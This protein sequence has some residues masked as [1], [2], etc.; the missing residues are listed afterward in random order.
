M[1][2]K[3]AKVSVSALVALMFQS[4]Y[5]SPSPFAK[6]FLLAA[7][8]DQK[9]A[10]QTIVDSG[11]GHR[12]RVIDPDKV[13]VDIM[14]AFPFVEQ[15]VIERKLE[16]NSNWVPNYSLSEIKKCIETHEVISFDIFDTLLLR[17]YVRPSDLFVHLERL[18]NAQGFANARVEAERKARRKHSVKEDILFDEIYAEIAPQFKSLQSK[19]MA[20][21]RQTL[22]ANPEMKEAFDYAIR[23]GKRVVITSDMYLPTGSLQQILEEKGYAGFHK[24]YVSGDQGKTKGTGSLFDY[25]LQDE[26]IE[27][28]ASV[29]HIGDSKHSDK[30]MAEKKG[31]SAI[32]Y[33]KRI[34]RL[35]AKDKRAKIFYD[36]HKNELDAS[37]LLGML[38]LSNLTGDYWEDF[39][40]TYAGPTILGFMKWLDKQAQKDGRKEILFVARD[41]YTPEKVF[42]IIKIGEDI[43]TH[44]VYAPRKI[45]RKIISGDEKETQNFARYLDKLGI[46]NEKLMLVDSV[47]SNLSSQRAVMITLPGKDIEGCY[48]IFEKSFFEKRFGTSEKYHVKTYQSSDENKFRNW[49]LVELI[50]TAPTPSIDVISDDCK[51]VFKNP[52]KEE[53]KR[54]EIYPSILNGA[55]KFAQTYI[56]I[57]N[58]KDI[59]FCAEML[60]NWIN[61][62]CDIPTKI[63]KEYFVDIKHAGDEN[64]SSYHQIMGKWYR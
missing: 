56:D 22:I 58:K 21:E 39:G 46:V 61:T 3:T 48:W 18:E 28:A 55:V 15:K 35:L 34:D 53:A 44:Y 2:F 4:G 27:S 63:D 36:K 57:F 16:I 6:A 41:G 33:P 40:Y 54:I 37:I 17:P 31:I 14:K 23:Q 10:V 60:T 9:A 45:S 24:I 8:G 1:N 19:E 11:Q 47:S 29:L 12:L 62:F 5:G 20:L 51:P 26:Q 32:W 59:H 42:N 38:A 64:H 7:R 13:P 43:R 30:D 49:E 50:M 52:S 25:L